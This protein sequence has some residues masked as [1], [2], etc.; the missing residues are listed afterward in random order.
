MIKIFCDIC[1]KDTNCDFELQEVNNK[2]IIGNIC[3]NCYAERILPMFR[4]NFTRII[5]EPKKSEEVCAD[6]KDLF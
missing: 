2:K 4:E 5:N 1:G 3:Q 6:K